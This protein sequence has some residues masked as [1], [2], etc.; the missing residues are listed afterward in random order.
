MN[1]M[2]NEN[3]F[4][5]E[6]KDIIQRDNKSQ[7][8]IQ[9]FLLVSI[10][11]LLVGI[12]ILFSILQNRYNAQVEQYNEQTMAFEQRVKKLK[13]EVQVELDK[14]ESAQDVNMSAI[15]KLKNLD[16][17]DKKQIEL[18]WKSAYLKHKNSIE[19]LQ[20]KV[21]SNF[22]QL[23]TQLDILQTDS[24]NS[25]NVKLIEANELIL[26]LKLELDSVIVLNTSL[27]DELDSFKTDYSKYK[28]L[29]IKQYQE[30]N[31]LINEYQ[32][33][34]DSIHKIFISNLKLVNDSLKITL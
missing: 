33:S 4:E 34:N 12:F 31:R 21:D 26:K 25:I 10:P 27:E 3:N 22:V 6:L 15:E 1:E 11:L 18:I 29:Y 5:Q 32:E 13:N 23:S 20:S 19:K 8:R 24:L 7:K 2:H 14:L 9:F 30:F 28:D 16:S 17:D